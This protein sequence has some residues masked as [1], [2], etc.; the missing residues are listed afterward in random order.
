M[1]Q[2][3]TW[4]GGRARP[5]RH[6]VRC[7]G[8]QS[9]LSRKGGR[10]PPSIFGPCLLWPNGWMDQDATWY[11]CI[12]LGPDHILLHGHPAP[13]NFRSTSIVAIRS[14]ISATVEHLVVGGLTIVT[15]RPNYSVCNNGPHLRTYLLQCGLTTGEWVS[16]FL[17]A[18]Q[19]V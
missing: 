14:P 9:S 19:H 4:Y 18:D 1:N 12:G 15:D 13:P 8:T 6:C 5:M 3:A 7:M 16:S 2:D 17:T 11:G 10:A